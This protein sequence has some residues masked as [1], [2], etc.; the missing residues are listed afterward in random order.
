MRKPTR[1]ATPANTGKL[2]QKSN[3]KPPLSFFSRPSAPPPPTS[4][5]V[6]LSDVVDAATT[7]VENLRGQVG[8]FRPVQ[9]FSGFALATFLFGSTIFATGNAIVGYLAEGGNGAVLERTLQFGTI[10]DD[11]MS[12]YVDRDLDLN[13]LFYTGVNSMLS[14][15]D[16]YSTYENPDESEDLAMR[17][18]GR[19]GGV[20]ITI[21]KDENDVLVLGALEGFAYDAGVRPGDRILAVDGKAVKERSVDEVK[22]MLR[23]EPGTSLA[24]TVQRDGAVEPTLT[25]PVKRQLVRLPDVTLATVDRAT[26]VGY[27]KLEGFSEGTAEEIARAIRKMQ[28]ERERQGGEL[29]AL[30][31]DMRDN[32]GGLLDS[33]VAVSQ[34]LVPEGTEIVS[35]SGRIY[36]EGATL[37][38][39]STRP[40]LLSPKTRLVVLVNAN[41]ASAAEIVTGVVQDTDRGVVV[42]ERTYGKGLV[43]IVEP[44]PGGGA[45]KLTVAKYYTPS[46]RCIQAVSYAGSRLEAKAATPSGP[47]AQTGLQALPADPTGPGGAADAGEESESAVTAT[48][49]LEAPGSQGGGS[50]GADGAA[51]DSTLPGAARRLNPS[52]P[53]RPFAA[54]KDESTKFVT[55]HGREVKAGGGI[56]PDVDVTGRELGELERSLLQRGLFFEFS[57]KWLQDHAVTATNGPEALARNVVKSQDDAYKQFISF[58]RQKTAAGGEKA[59]GGDAAPGV[60]LESAG[61]QKQLDALSKSIGAGESHKGSARELAQLRKLILE[62]QLDEFRSQKDVIQEDLKEA[63]LGRLTSPSVRL[64][65]QMATDKQVGE[66]RSI[67]S[68]PVR[69]ARILEA[70][71]TKEAEAILDLT[72][73]AS[74]TMSLVFPLQ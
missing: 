62:E 13:K 25:M 51:G 34:Q 17:T 11:V 28:I 63:L 73:P 12:G 67:A 66:A 7:G 69:Y 3:T 39:R 24:L 26:G 59:A 2:T 21:G 35:T 41:T 50:K 5:R 61:L 18:T 22:S 47:D 38:Y 9:V 14:T 58:V 20:G 27:V 57:G 55:A 49:I 46:G 15:L 60:R 44:L 43:Q 32:P 56:A 72:S 36:G 52:E 1:P 74:K 65:A 10:L 4:P 8:E 64:A 54:V 48:P 53:S 42:G 23:G 19:Y 29:E 30:I 68:D 6:R 31:L 71:E 33:A 70:P 37:S 40:P 16:P 45:L